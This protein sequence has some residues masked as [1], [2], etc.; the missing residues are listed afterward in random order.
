MRMMGG[1]RT[2]LAM[3]LF[4][5]PPDSYDGGELVIDVTASHAA[6][7]S[8]PVRRWCIRPARC[9]ASKPSPAAGARWRSRG[10]KA[11]SATRGQREII[12]DLSETI[13]RLRAIQPD[14][15]DALADRKDTCQ[16]A[17]DVG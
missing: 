17:P 6:S 9:I 4:L 15:Q 16:S 12:I 8:P 11:C 1:T 14:A 3:T 10:Y 7:S 13:N 2:D 5:S